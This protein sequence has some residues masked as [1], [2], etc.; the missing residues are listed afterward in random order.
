MRAFV[1]FSISAVTLL[2]VCC[3]PSYATEADRLYT[4]G[5]KYYSSG[6]YDQAEKMFRRALARDHGHQSSMYMM[7][8]TL[9]TDIRK[10][11][12][13]E[14]WYLDARKKAEVTG[15]DLPKVLYS[16]GRLYI[17]LGH[18]DDAL[19]EFDRL[20]SVSPDFYELARVYNHMGVASFR[21]DRY[22]ESLDYFKAALK[23]SPDMPEA[24]FNMKTVQG[25]LSSLNNARYQERMGNTA[26]A[27]RYYNEAIDSYPDYVA[28]WYQLGKVYLKEG[29]YDNAVKRLERAWILN[30][31]YLGGNEIPYRLALAYEGRAAKGDDGMALSLYETL[32]E[33]RGSAIRAGSLYTSLGMFEDAEKVLKTMTGPDKGRLDRAEAFYRLG[34]LYRKT[35]R[36]DEATASFLGALGA[37]PEVEKYRT[38]PAP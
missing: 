35:G 14:K 30:Q 10:L 4:T 37:A 23:T 16:L 22:D 5:S 15:R 19:G 13:A 34:V 31:S 11:G 20:L 33:Y 3:T 2:A 29:D 8:E 36:N 28:A 38:P 7:G 18:Y 6:D 21:L 26:E 27:I 1:I 9:S 24:I 12:E 32:G 25:R 17:M